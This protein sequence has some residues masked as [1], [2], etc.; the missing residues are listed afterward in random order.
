MKNKFDF[1]TDE[2]S[3]KFSEEIAK[4]MVRLFGISLE[5]ALKRVNRHWK[6][7]DLTGTENIVYHEDETF[8]ANQI[9]YDDSSFW[10]IKGQPVT[11]RKMD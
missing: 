2:D 1:L 9:Y 7:Q 3:H 5:E 8:W 10:W 11:P 6:G 4:E